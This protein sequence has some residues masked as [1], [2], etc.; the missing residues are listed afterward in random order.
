MCLSPYLPTYPTILI[1]RA[2]SNTYHCVGYWFQPT[3]IK[4]MGYNH[5]Y[6]LYYYPSILCAPDQISSPLTQDESHMQYYTEW[7]NNR[8]H[9]LI[10][11]VMNNVYYSSVP[12]SEVVLF[13]AITPIASWTATTFSGRMRGGGA[14]FFLLLELLL[15][16]GSCWCCCLERASWAFSSFSYCW[17]AP[18]LVAHSF[19]PLPR[20]K[21]PS[22]EEMVE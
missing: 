7:N 1:G 21:S 20:A 10:K 12:F 22:W 9:R 17:I 18:S 8:E 11:L 2:R 5:Q 4:V 14:F 16:W 19:R 15:W 13:T 3:F 6:I